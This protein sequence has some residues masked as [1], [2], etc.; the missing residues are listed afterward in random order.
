MKQ[1]KDYFAFISYKRED[2]KW[3]KW[4]QDKLEHYKFPT[5]LNGRT[6]LP[7]TIRPTFRDVTDLKP[8]LL[9]EEINNALHNSEW[10]IVVCSPRSAKSPWVCKEA[11]TFIDLNRADHIIPFVIEGNPFS[12]DIATEC[13]PEALLN[14][15]GSKELL[16]ANI[17]EMGRDAAAIKV[18][19][20]MFNLRFDSLWQ[21]HEREKEKERQKLI[22]TNNKILS[23]QSRYVA[24]YA[25]EH[26]ANV[27][28]FLARRLALEILPRNLKKPNRPYTPEA[29]SLLRLS[30]KKHNAIIKGHQ[31]GV[32]YVKLC[33]SESLF[34]SISFDNTI[35]IWDTYSGRC[36]HVF[37]DHADSINHAVFTINDNKVI[38]S[39]DDKTIRV[40]N[41]ETGLCESVMYQK[42]F[43]VNYIAIHPKENLLAFG[44]EDGKVRICDID[45]FQVQKIINTGSGSVSFVSYSQNGDKM[46]I[47]SGH[48][49]MIWD[50]YKVE[51]MALFEAGSNIPAISADGKMLL[52]STDTWIRIYDINSARLI[53]EICDNN[54]ELTDVV[55][56]KRNNWLIASSCYSS[57]SGK[58]SV[59]VFDILSSKCIYEFF[60]HSNQ[61]VS[62]DINSDNTFII[63]A[64][65]DSTI[66]I[67]DVCTPQYLNVTTESGL[68]KFSFD[69]RKEC[70]I[71][72]LNHNTIQFTSIN[73][74]SLKT[75]N[76]VLNTGEI[77][78]ILISK[79]GKYLL[80]VH[81]KRVIKIWN[82]TSFSCVYTSSQFDYDI[83]DVSWSP[84]EQYIAITSLDKS[85]ACLLNL[86]S[87]ENVL[88]GDN[89]YI[90]TSVSFHPKGKYIA[91]SY[92]NHIAIVWN[93]ETR[94]KKF[95]LKGHIETL[96]WIEYSSNGKYIL[97]TSSDNTIRVWN[98][99]NGTCINTLYG[100]TADVWCARFNARNNC[101]I[102]ASSDKCICI[103]DIISGLC[104]D[105]YIFDDEQLFVS[106]DPKCN[107]IMALSGEIIRIWEFPSLQQLINE[108]KLIFKDYPLTPE[109]RRKYY[110]E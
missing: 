75:K 97:T 85:G 63:T 108:T 40:W 50:T 5:N 3:A 20:R 76:V 30:V 26:L 89:D 68:R 84:D 15:T 29:D 17:N 38:S 51:Q 6:D 110:L 8:G 16:A 48:D 52:T 25:I 58:S 42:D 49:L 47:K 98:A 41:V 74:Y 99:D 13:Y 61:V 31:H 94:E 64:S 77:N 102:S 43:I 73:H 1:D 7:K 10:L 69:S 19:A 28:S 101:I 90:A 71:T 18:V 32:R 81:K 109:E 24:Q 45:T 70:I 11:Q 60:G 35:R 37:S 82:N 96:I 22:R 59:C 39:S 72:P 27:D 21:R 33:H 65:Y 2:E 86:E 54:H 44:S 23:S 14:L 36:V 78:L 55:F 66:R 93:I 9:A 106:I 56:D 95:L 107:K 80:T 87:Q 79:S 62:A 34:L 57:P 91:V 67:W 12:N 100:H 83:W 104:I 103:W 46:V 4:L 105:K 53:K 88:I 92:I